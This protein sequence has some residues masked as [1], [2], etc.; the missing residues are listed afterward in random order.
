MINKYRLRIGWNK[1]D[2]MRSNALQE[3][4]GC[5][6]NSCL[7]VPIKKRR[8]YALKIETL[9]GTDKADSNKGRISHT[10]FINKAQGEQLLKLSRR[11]TTGG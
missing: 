1:L 2:I 5:S 8:E 9:A 4:T 11:F 6:L 3:A 10:S 7:G